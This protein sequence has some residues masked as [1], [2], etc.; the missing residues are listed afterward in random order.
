MTPG[1]AR[2][3]R[4]WV[5]DERGR[6]ELKASTR[7]TVC[8]EGEGCLTRDGLPMTDF[9]LGS[10]TESTVCDRAREVSGLGTNRGGGLV[11]RGGLVPEDL[12]IGR[13]DLR[14][15]GPNGDDGRE[16]LEGRSPSEV[17]LVTGA[18][19]EGEGERVG[20]AG[21]GLSGRRYLGTGIVALE[22]AVSRER[23]PVGFER[24]AA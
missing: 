1:G 7:G 10:S 9:S 14:G 22:R 6:I 24:G 20:G 8:C 17:V 18:A 4:V 13:R 5:V 3:D 16:R 19:A 12:P 2:A 21:A 23:R 15:R 11:A